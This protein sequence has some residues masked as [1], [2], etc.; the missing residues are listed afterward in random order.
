MDK[1]LVIEKIV[2]YI[3]NM[4]FGES[5]S[6]RTICNSVSNEKY[7][8]EELF[9][10]QEI[11][12]KRCE[13]QGI[14]CDYSKYDGAIVGLPYDLDFVKKDIDEIKLDKIK[15]MFFQNNGEFFDNIKTYLIETFD[16][17]LL[18]NPIDNCIRFELH[19]K[20][21]NKRIFF[22]INKNLF[23]L[24]DFS[25]HK[26]NLRGNS[27]EEK[28]IQLISKLK[29]ITNSWNSSYESA[30]EYYWGLTICSDN[31]CDLYVGKS[32]FPNNWNELVTE[33]NNSI[34]E[35]MNNII[36]ETLI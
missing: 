18:S 14:I 20:T 26:L 32:S 1:N 19:D 7:D 23:L 36:K 30:G 24:N 28:L 13:E 11:V 4:K 3:K 6:I 33:L 8:F 25:K 2:D 34:E 27:S 29:E 15:N 10:I 9:D 35:L 12:I 5:S 22:A 21:G 17:D 16:Y 31:K